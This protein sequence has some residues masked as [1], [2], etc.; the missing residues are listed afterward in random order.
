MIEALDADDVRRWCRVAADSLGLVREEIDAL[1]VFPV[2][3]S[4][5][6]TNLYLTMLAAAEAVESLERDADAGRTWR[7][8]ARAA[9]LGARGNSGVIV[10]QVLR[11]LADVLPARAPCRGEA[12]RRGLVHAA[13]LA[14]GAVGEPVEGTVLS[15]LRAAGDAA[16]VAAGVNGDDLPTVAR[17]GAV[18]ARD[19]LARTTGQLDV[20]AANGVVDAGAAGLCVILDTFAAVVAGDRAAGWHV[21][22]PPR[23]PAP[24]S[25]EPRHE[26]SP[27]VGPAY[28]VMYLLDADAHR[29]TGLRETL[30]GLGESLVVVGGG[31]LWNVHVHVDDVG[32]AIEA[33]IGAGRPHR[34]RVTYLHT[35]QPRRRGGRGVVAVAAGEGIEGLFAHAGA[36]VVPRTPDGCPRLRDLTEAVRRAGDEV[37]LLPNESTVLATAEA[38]AERARDEDLRVY[39]IPTRACVQGLAALA[40]HDPGRRFDDDVIAMTAAAG[41][42]RFGEITVAGRTAVTSAGICAPGDVLGLI[43]GDVAVLG[44]SVADTAIAVVD[45]MLS[46]GGELVTLITGSGCEEGLA[47][48]IVRGL[49]HTRPDV[50]TLVYDGSQRDLPLLVGVE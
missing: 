22:V 33:G 37:V 25:G 8:L 36:A 45:R 18:G 16:D 39:V 3:D 34:I 23:R 31:G 9:L 15:V 17:A 44:S 12:F 41:A 14:Y 29:A 5:T 47:D 24:G 28:E 2:P 19:A 49:R 35:A 4:D 27:Y 38:A 13:A 20:L 43:D 21:A 10:S 26:E 50:D 46:G 11:A 48:R 1:N 6:G 40:V 42:T 7:T 30:R 32:A